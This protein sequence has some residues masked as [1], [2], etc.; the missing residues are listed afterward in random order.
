MS[1]DTYAT[2]NLPA[3]RANYALAKR[4][5]K[6]A[7]VLAVLKA[8]A[9]GHGLEQVAGALA[10]ADGFAVALFEEAITLRQL[11]Y[12]QKIVVLQGGYK[13]ADFI[14]AAALNLSLVVHQY[15]QWQVLAS[16]KQIAKPL[17]IWLKLDTGMHRL[18]FSLSEGQEVL[19]QMQGC[20]Y[21]AKKT[22]MTHFAC[23][24]DLTNPLTLKQLRALQKWNEP[25]RLPLS[26]ANSAGL[27]GWHHSIGQWTRP[28]IMLY[29]ASPFPHQDGKALGLKPVMSLKSRLIAIKWVEAG[30]SVG[31]GA[32]WY[33]NSRT[34]IGI[35]AI[36]YGDGYPR[37]AVTG[38]PIVVSGQR[39]H[40]IGR[41]SMDMLAVD[42]SHCQNVS[43]YDEVELWGDTLSVDE[44]A[45]ASGT[46]AYEL[47]V[48]ITPRVPMRYLDD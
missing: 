17:D 32:A 41:V 9:Y 29:G 37:H 23:A 46:L 33:A 42:L 3:L 35:V 12:Q 28:G 36:G 13:A 47:L 2:V 44:V 6:G 14:E 10:D 4:A 27:L 16:L 18:G 19:Q 8:N 25:W 24:D 48:G 34:L 38:T 20:K 1:R 15:Q 5:A 30:E 39:A 31:Y 7:G 26:S 22:I 21:I 40:I 43:L 11:G 45:R